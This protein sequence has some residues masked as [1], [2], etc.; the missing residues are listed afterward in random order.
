VSYPTGEPPNHQDPAGIPPQPPEAQQR[1]RRTDQGQSRDPATAPKTQQGS[2][3]SRRHCSTNPGSASAVRS[4][5][6]PD[7]PDSWVQFGK[8]DDKL[9][10]MRAHMD[11]QAATGLRAA[12]ATHHVDDYVARARV[13]RRAKLDTDVKNPARN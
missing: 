13:A 9:A 7:P 1:S 10:I 8:D 12:L 3:Y 4:P 5:A 11:R 2:R 6:T